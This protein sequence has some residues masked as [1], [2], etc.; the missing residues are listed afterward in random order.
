MLDHLGA[1]RAIPLLIETAVRGTL[2]LVAALGGA[3]LCRRATA[4]TRQRM[5][6]AAL[7][8]IAVL[9]LGASVAPRIP[10]PFYVRAVSARAVVTP[11]LQGVSQPA[12]RTSDGSAALVTGAWRANRPRRIESIVTTGAVL[13]W[14]VGALVVF[15][16][17]MVGISRVRRLAR[18]AE[19][20]A[21]PE[22][23]VQAQTI[24]R[25]LHIGRPVRVL[26]SNAP[27]VPMTW[28]VV[29][30]A[31][32]LPPNALAWS[33]MRRRTVL[34]HE[35]AHVARCD[36]LTQFIAL[37]ARMLLWFH[38][39]IRVAIRRLR[40]ESERACDDLVLACG[41]RPSEYAGELMALMRTLRSLH[42]PGVA[43]LTMARH[44]EF[45]ERL[46]AILDPDLCRT[47]SGR[48]TRL[49]SASVAVPLMLVI[50]TGYP[51][52]HAVPA[53]RRDAEPRRCEVKVDFLSSDVR[54]GAEEDHGEPGAVVAVWSP[55]RSRAV[56]AVAADGRCLIARAHG[57]MTFDDSWSD[58]TSVTSGGSFVLE[59]AVGGA[60]HKLIMRND[61]GDLVRQYTVDDQ[62]RPW[63]EGRAWY[64]ATLPLLVGE[65]DYEAHERVVALRARRGVSA[66]LDAVRRTRRHL[67]R[68]AYFDALIDAGP[69][70]DTERGQAADL[71]VTMLPSSERAR[72]LARLGVEVRS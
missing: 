42:D 30:P 23:I 61:G 72:V 69:L 22:W 63:E 16:R 64:A 65:T 52:T 38:P 18:A 28:G 29:Y 44:V 51:V 36:S 27:V 7:L 70:S 40:A 8:T 19:P 10:L 6:V 50:A 37:A 20:I 68:V 14:I 3:A 11:R 62:E 26:V 43:A 32:L 60:K 39:L 33:P 57:Q 49:A 5:W 46:L 24:A 9:P 54:V 12:V 1:S 47:S 13:I 45:E 55:D 21:D 15:G 59:E 58:V 4:A 71:A 53:V 34:L 41:T 17:A 66:V 25:S 56:I 31:I 48:G 35:L 2:V 67:T